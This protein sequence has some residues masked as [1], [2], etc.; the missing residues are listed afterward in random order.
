MALQS[1]S[2]LPSTISTYKE[3]VF[4]CSIDCHSLQSSL[5]PECLPFSGSIE[6]YG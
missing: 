5:L 4:T 6:W 1:T 2:V 3:V